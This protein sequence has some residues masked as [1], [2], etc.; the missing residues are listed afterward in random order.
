MWNMGKT[1]MGRRRT[2]SDGNQTSYEYSGGSGKRI[3]L[4]TVLH[5]KKRLSF[6]P[7]P[8][9]ISLTHL[10][11]AGNNLKIPGQEEFG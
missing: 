10:S 2:G 5:C 4:G 3:Q 7:Y 1:K 8:A 9:G 11:L 6:F